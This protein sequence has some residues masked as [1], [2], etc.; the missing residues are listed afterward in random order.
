MRELRIGTWVA[1]MVALVAFGCDDED[2][3][4]DGGGGGDSGMVGTDGGGGGD[5]DSGSG[6]GTDGG[7]TMVD[8][9]NAGGSCGPTAGECDLTDPASCGPGMACIL[10]GD[11][12]GGTIRQCFAAGTGMDGA[13]CDPMMVGQCS[14][15]FGCSQY[16]DVCR[17]NCCSD[18]DCNPPGMATGQIC[19]K[20]SNGGPP[21]MEAGVCI[22]GDDCSPVEQTG[23]D[24]DEACNILGARGLTLCGAPGTG[25]AG[26]DCSENGCVAGTICISGEPARCRAYCDT[27]ASSP[28]PT[29]F[30]CG[31]LSEAPE[32]VGVCVPME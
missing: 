26:A 10:N 11:N 6:G 31:G 19:R 14:E 23:C 30:A 21:G 27:N 7:M 25:A 2:G 1:V 20:F 29:G 32:G 17:R 16:E 3:G 13:T 24:G 8:S 15:G 4:R 12:A 22:A 5:V 28:C 9:G 18:A